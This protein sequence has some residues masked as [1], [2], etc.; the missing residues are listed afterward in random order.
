MNKKELFHQFVAFTATVHQ[1]T[2]DLTKNIKIDDITPIQYKILEY[3]TINRLITPTEVSDCLHLSMPNTSRELRKLREKNWIEKINDTKDRRK[4]YI[5]LT[6]KGKHMM[7]EA[8]TCIETRFQ[9]LIENSSNEE[10]EE[11]RKALTTLQTKIFLNQ[12]V[13]K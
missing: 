8:F 11:I 13:E 6:E 9:K 2:H 1:V 10:L 7:D 12:S 5:R 3:I 4:H